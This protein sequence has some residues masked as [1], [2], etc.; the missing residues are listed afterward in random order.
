MRHTFHAKMIHDALSDPGLFISFHF[1]KRALL[2]DLGDL[3]GLLPK[4]LL[5]V[6]HVFVSHAHMDHFIGFD[7]LLRTFLGR[8]RFVHFFGPPGFFGH[9]EGKLAGY[10]WN[11]VAEHENELTLSVSETHPNEILT[12]T[13]NSRQRFDPSGHV[14]RRPFSGTLHKEPA[15]S[16]EGVLLDHRIPCLGLSLIENFTVNIIKEALNDLE[17]PVGPWL[18]RF[19]AAVYERRSVNSEF[20]IRWKTTDGGMRERRMVFGDLLEK[21]A[22]ISP[23]R[24]VTYITDVAASSENIEKAARLASGSD[25]LFIEAAFLESEKRLAGKTYHLTARQAGELAAR[26]GA[27]RFEIFHFSPRYQGRTGELKREANQG[28]HDAIR[29]LC[30]YRGADNDE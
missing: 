24:K 23:G 10:T 7:R 15:F 25:I 13:Y 9:V 27:K 26:S 22:V 18:T 4:D 6:T 17:L 12:K 3:G 5:K 14:A 16:V 2:F 30:G 29:P 1:R 19:K 21:I 8:D 20:L 11:L 28:Y